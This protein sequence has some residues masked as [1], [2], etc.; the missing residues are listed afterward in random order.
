MADVVWC[1]D[2]LVEDVVCAE[3]LVEVARVAAVVG[4]VGFADGEGAEVVGVEVR[5][6]VGAEVVVVIAEQ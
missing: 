1:A 5:E 6:G 4:C 3:D 2:G